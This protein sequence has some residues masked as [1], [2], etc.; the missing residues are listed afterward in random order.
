[1]DIIFTIV[2][3]WLCLTYALIS[4]QTGSYASLMISVGAVLTLL[5]LAFT[6]DEK[7]AWFILVAGRVLFFGGFAVIL[8]FEGAQERARFRQSSWK[9]ILLGRV[10]EHL[11]SRKIS[12]RIQVIQGLLLSLLFAGIFYLV[13]RQQEALSFLVIA[14]VFVAYLGVLGVKHEG[15]S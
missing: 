13:D 14:I 10:P 2:L 4:T 3:A 15:S 8:T 11:Q 5:A 7:I 9:E 6:Q 12:E 1:M